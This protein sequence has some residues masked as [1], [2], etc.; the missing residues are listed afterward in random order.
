MLHNDSVTLHTNNLLLEG[1]LTT[2][3]N[4]IK[5]STVRQVETHPAERHYVESVATTIELI[6][7]VTVGMVRCVV[8]LQFAARIPVDKE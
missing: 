6:K 2:D 4:A 5:L 3:T 1:N 7:E 8:Y